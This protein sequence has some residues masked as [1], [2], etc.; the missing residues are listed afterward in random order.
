MDVSHC[1][2]TLCSRLLKMGDR[3]CSNPWS[4]KPEI[5]KES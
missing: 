3:N 1:L 4:E 5:L 2:E